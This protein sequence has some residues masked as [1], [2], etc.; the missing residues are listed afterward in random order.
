[1]RGT[2]TVTV[3]A[4]KQTETL[5]EV[6]VTVTAVGAAEI[7]RFNYDKV[8]DITSRIPTLNVQTGGSGSG[9]SLSLRGVG[10]SYISAAFDS[11]VALDFDGMQV[12]SMRVLQSAF[13]DVRQIEVLKGPQSLYFGKSASAGVLSIKSA[14]PTDDWE[15]GGK[16]AYEFEEDGLT[17]EASVSGPVTDKFG[18]R[19]AA[20]YNDIRTVWFNTAPV[21]DPHRGE[22]NLNIRATFEFEPTDNFTANLK[23]NYIRHANDGAI[24][25]SAMDCGPNGVPDSVFLLSGALPIP[26][27]Y[28]C[29]ETGK[30]PVFYLPDMAPA[31]SAQAP[32]EGPRLKGGIPYGRSDIYFG[33][34]KWDWNITGSLTLSSVSGYL[35]QSAQDN[36]SYSYGGVIAGVGQ[37]AGTGLTD[38]QL[39]QFSQ[40]VRLRS[41]FDHWFNFMVGAFYEDRHIEFNTSQNAVNISFFSPDPITGN[42]FDWYKEH[43]T[44]T[45]AVSVFGS[46]TIN[47]TDE[48]ELSGGVR[49]THEKKVNHILVPYVHTFLVATGAFIQ[50]GFDS[51]PIE[52]RDNNIS[53][54][55]TLSWQ[56][57]DDIKLYASY[58]TG[59]KSGGIDNSALPSSNLLGFA[60]PDPEVRQAT[61]DAL[62]YE[63]ETAKGGEIGVKSQW[64]DRSLTLNLSAFYYVFKNLQVQNFDAVAIQFLTAN[65]GEVTTKGV[66]LDWRWATPLDGLSL[67]GSM[68]FLSNKYTAF[69]DP[70]PLD[71]VSQNLEG[72]D[73]LQSP[74]FS[75]NAAFDWRVPLGNSLELGLTGNARY[76]GSFFTN[77]SNYR[78]RAYWTFDLAASIGDPEGRWRLSMIGTN[79]T[80]KHYLQSS[81]PRPF[82]QPGVGDD[83]IFTFARGRQLTV[84]ASFRF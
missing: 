72:R 8:A 23:L 68:T 46:A 81:G 19:L 62:V 24:Q 64:A 37:G 27:G 42:S 5:Q 76:S 66:D 12:S 18:F 25:R 56:A 11:A 21:A 58:K 14:D 35:D 57:T 60:S 77:F 29:Y 32:A 4:R 16:V 20:R 59:F 2:E 17:T 1:M 34:L 10:S 63:S 50:S 52:F 44:D 15:F 45:S 84:E 9:A 79:L 13:M 80:D 49:W 55:V 83:E 71:G 82:L 67:Y 33:V 54:E 26:A 75:G 39:R 70:N 30:Q 28:P 22:R 73:G 48:L 38:N 41:D 61:A 51:G 78:Q 74:D 3:T 7:D 69:F 53:P 6:P 47:F 65:A 43:P 36:D 40:E 31:L